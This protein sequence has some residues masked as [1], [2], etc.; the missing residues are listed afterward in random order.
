ML[1]YYIRYARK[2]IK[3][4]IQRR[5]KKKFLLYHLFPFNT[6]KVRLKDEDAY[7]L[8]NIC[9]MLDKHGIRYRLT[10]GVALG[11]YREH[12]FIRHDTDLDFDLMDFDSLETLKEQMK[13][14][15]YKIG[16]EV[17][18]DSQIQQIVFYNKNQLIVDFSIWYRKDGELRHYGEKGYVRIQELQYFENLTD[19]DC[20]GYTFKLPGHLEEW[21]VKRFGDDWQTP[22]T[23]KGDWKQDCFDI[24][25]LL[26]LIMLFYLIVSCPSYA[27]KIG[28]E[29]NALGFFK[30]Y[31]GHTSSYRRPNTYAGFR[32]QPQ[33]SLSVVDQTHQLV[34]GYDA[35]LEW[36][37]EN[38]LD[39]DGFL[40]YYKYQGKH[41]RAII[42][43]YPR[44]LMQE[45][46]PE[47]LICDSIQIYRPNMTGFDFLYTSKSGYIE[48]FL[49]W[50]SKRG[51]F[52]REQFMAGGML[53]FN[54][55]KFQIGANGY[56]YHYALEFKNDESYNIHTMHDNTMIHP[57]VA[58]Q[59]RLSEAIDSLGVRAGMLINFDRDRGMEDKPHA[60]MGFL[61]EAGFQWK[62]LGI[63]E[64]FYWGE[65]LQRLGKEGFGEYYW[66]DPFY[67]SPIYSRTDL[68]YDIVSDRYATL[69]VGLN[70]HITDKGIQTCQMIT[71]Y[72]T[73]PGKNLPK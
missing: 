40:A 68:S 20:Y 47:Y 56:Y 36:G 62:R 17:Y 26:S 57:Y 70:V 67:Q 45:T 71:L 13:N 2:K 38:H 9:E 22:R 19:Y 30:N 61:G 35:L 8:H 4:F 7:E 48:A 5:A 44:R 33:V 46:M 69:R 49:D 10:D 53:R 66:G 6:L 63:C 58:R 41:L 34:A 59:F 1:L 55:G 21:L 52:S 15:G 31:E 28:W 23:Y 29:A 54:I 11:F 24:K 43:K 65:G 73:L 72:A 64:T 14:R 37:G 25:P 42:G 12:H 16:R 51:A 27:Q 3:F 18:Y 32:L 39:A 50:T 60:R